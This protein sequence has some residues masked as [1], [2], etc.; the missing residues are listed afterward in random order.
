MQSLRSPFTT[1]VGLFALSMMTGMLRAAEPLVLPLW[2]DGTPGVGSDAEEKVTGPTG[3]KPDRFISNVRHPTLTVYLPQKDH[4]SGAAVVICPG[5]GYSGVAIDK[6]GHDVARWLNTLG[7]AGVVLKYRMPHPDESHG[8]KPWPLQDAQRAIRTVRSRA[9]E[10]NI[11][12]KKVGIMGFSAGG[13]LA[14]TVGTH[15]DAGNPDAKDPIDRPGSRP[16]FMILCY[17]VVTLKSD[18]AH[19]GSRDNLLGKNADDKLRAEYSAE[20]NV[21][22]ETPPTFIVHTKDDPV[23]VRN[24]IALKEAMDKAGVPCRLELYDKGGHGYGL[25][26]N[27]GEVATWPQRCAEWLKDRKLA[28][29]S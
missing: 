3:D 5:G 22:P 17:P 12:P 20:L 18:W 4:A 28:N 24:S 10:W 27:G 13:H 23:K 8:Q 7:I 15:F 1:L 19:T 2:P 11:D 26:V 9:S 25:G 6:E 14:S 29:A 16:D 21:T